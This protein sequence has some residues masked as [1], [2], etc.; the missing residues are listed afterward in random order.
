[1]QDNNIY[2]EVTYETVKEDG[3][4]ALESFVINFGTKVTP[5]VQKLDEQH[6]AK[7]IRHKEQLQEFQEIP[8]VDV[9]FLNNDEE[10]FIANEVSIDEFLEVVG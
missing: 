7:F 4:K 9:N 8:I 6:L 5:D 2:L 1:M 3:A 10:P